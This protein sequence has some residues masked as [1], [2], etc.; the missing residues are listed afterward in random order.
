LLSFRDKAIKEA[1]FKRQWLSISITD[2][3]ESV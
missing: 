2:E 3:S 1:C